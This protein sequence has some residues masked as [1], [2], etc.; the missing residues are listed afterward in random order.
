[1]NWMIVDC[2]NVC[3]RS[4]HTTGHLTDNGGSRTGV[5]FGFLNQLSSLVH[6]F[7]PDGVVF[8][9]DYGFSKR[10][11]LFPGYKANRMGNH[12]NEYQLKERSEARRQIEDLRITLL[13]SLGFQNVFWQE[14][15]EA[16]DVIASVC[17]S[18]LVEGDT[19]LLVSSDKDLLQLL[20][21][22]CVD[23]WDFGKRVTA[24]AFEKQWG[25]QPPEW[26]KV[27][28]LAGC[29]GDCVPGI[30]RVGEKTAVKFLRG[31]FRKDK[32][33]Q[34][35]G[36]FYRSEDYSR[37]LRLVELPYPGTKTFKL[38]KDRPDPRAWDQLCRE[39]RLPSLV[40]RCPFSGFAKRK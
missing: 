28:A 40:G 5:V 38:R 12:L 20:H 25:V 23:I 8:A 17:H 26:A 14:G 19:A 2:H 33:G 35:I 16:D 3:W 21:D 1:M 36:E 32:R 6:H 15:Y 31:G 34:T 7:H 4:F 30:P 22:P 37:N 9:F 24:Q 10:K 13:E 11:E 29:A 39:L 18:T 27:K